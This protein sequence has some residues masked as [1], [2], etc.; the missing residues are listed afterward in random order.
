[1]LISVFF[2][3]SLTLSSPYIGSRW[4]YSLIQRIKIHYSLCSCIMFPYDCSNLRELDDFSIDGSIWKFQKM[5]FMAI[6]SF[7]RMRI[8]RK[9][10]SILQAFKLNAQNQRIHRGYVVRMSVSVYMCVK[11]WMSIYNEMAWHG[12]YYVIIIFR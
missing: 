7:Q 1:M 2:S 8:N 11:L 9:L 6:Y 4:M 10:Y 5:N 3:F 12:N